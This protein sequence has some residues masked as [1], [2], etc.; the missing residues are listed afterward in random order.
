MNYIL[1]AIYLL[2]F[3]ALLVLFHPIQ[4]LAFHVF[5]Y[6]AHAAVVDLLNGLIVYGW[7]IT[8]SRPLFSNS[9]DIPTHQPILFIANHQSTFDIPG[10]IWFL[11][12]YHPVFISKI[13]LAKGIP[14]ISRNLRY[15]G[16]ALIDRKDPK[17]AVSQIIGLAKNMQ[18]KNWNVAIFPEG[19][20]SRTAEIKPFATGGIAA[21]IKKVPELTVVVIKIENLNVFNPTKGMFPLRPF[22]PLRWTV[23]DVFDAKGI[24][25][26]AIADRAYAVI[27]QIA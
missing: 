22:T 2:Y 26:Q 7:Y 24:T 13:E 4:W 21:I 6:R 11:R 19:T 9:Y 5:G 10:L 15:S 18:T 20:R 25:A 14:S 8:G 3:G 1:S 16:A 17:Q 23:K 12:K 27:A